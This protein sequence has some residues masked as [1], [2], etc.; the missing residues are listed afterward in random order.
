MTTVVFGPGYLGRRLAASLPDAVLSTADVT[1]A[2]AVRAAMVA[3]NATAAVNAAGKTGRPNVDWCETHQRETWRA[4]VVGPLVIADVCA[5]LGAYLLHIG[6]GCVFY[7]PSPAPGGWRE[8]DHANPL[9][10]YSKS[11]Y[12]ADLALSSVPHVGVARIRMPLDETPDPRNLITKLSGYRFVIDVE[13]SVTVV[14][15]F[16]HVARELVARRASGVFHVTNPGVMRHRDLLD[17]YRRHVDPSHAAEFIPAEELTARGLA[18]AARS[19]CV[20][21]SDRLAALGVTMRPIADVL[22]GLVAEYARRR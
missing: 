17:A 10:Y 21:A 7:G 2:A 13:N 3:H 14:D 6:S 4:N 1:D 22:D 15:D 9:S 11:K 12:A 20:L 5:D 8:T 18:S 16:L 19:N